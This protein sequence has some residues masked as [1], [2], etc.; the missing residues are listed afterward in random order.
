MLEEIYEAGTNKVSD[1]MTNGHS[2]GEIPVVPVPRELPAPIRVLNG[3]HRILAPGN[4]PG[5]HARDGRG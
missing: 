1:S 2:Q 3:Q 5:E 4:P